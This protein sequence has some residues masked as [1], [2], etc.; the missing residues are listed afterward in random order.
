M[1]DEKRMGQV[2]QIDEARI[3]TIWARW[4]AGP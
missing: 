1:S 3:E 2:I 4:F